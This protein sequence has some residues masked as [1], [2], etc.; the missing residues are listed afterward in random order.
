MGIL[1]YVKQDFY[2]ACI[3]LQSIQE[4]LDL[5]P[6]DNEANWQKEFALLM[7]VNSLYKQYLTLLDKYKDTLGE[8]EFKRL[9][10]EAYS[11]A[12]TGRQYAN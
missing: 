11:M 8:E 12:H 9:R 4:V 10:M 2:K 7:E 1:E 3:E 5:K 6:L